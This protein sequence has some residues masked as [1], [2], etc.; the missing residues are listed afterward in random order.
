MSQTSHASSGGSAVSPDVVYAIPDDAAAVLPVADL[1]DA[2]T[3]RVPIGQ[4]HTTIT[5]VDLASVT[6]TGG[7]VAPIWSDAERVVDYYGLRP[8]VQAARGIVLEVFGRKA[9][10]CPEVVHEPDSGA[11]SLVLRIQI[12]EGQGDLRRA[13][14]KRYARETTLPENAPV[15]VVLWDYADAVSA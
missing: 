14:S 9:H 11:P 7:P 8:L 5:M 2:F 12:A 13:F 6:M 3:I 1:I 4:R 10:L 15:P